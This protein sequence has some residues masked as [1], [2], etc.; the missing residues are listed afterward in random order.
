MR[1]FSKEILWRGFVLFEVL[2][3]GSLL[4]LGFYVVVCG[5]C[6]YDEGWVCDGF[7]DCCVIVIEIL[8][9]YFWV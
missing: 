5:Y 1:C 4:I 7:F 6:M 2:L 9:F 8:V 3:V